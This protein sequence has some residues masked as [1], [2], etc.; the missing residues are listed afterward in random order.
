MNPLL[1]ECMRRT[2]TIIPRTPR[3]AAS[4]RPARTAAGVGLAMATALLASGALAQSAPPAPT[5]NHTW[6]G[7]T[8]DAQTVEAI[9][10]RINFGGQFDTQNP[11]ANFNVSF[12][13]VYSLSNDND[14]QPLKPPASGYTGAIL[15]TNPESVGIQTTTETATLSGVDIRDVEQVHILQYREPSGG[16][17]K[18]RV[19]SVTDSFTDCFTVSPP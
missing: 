18:K 7:C 4:R 2:S 12:I 10:N 17:T 6:G 14:G 3:A 5:A 16:P 1:R 11:N 13:L 15:C 8:L 9:K 19:C